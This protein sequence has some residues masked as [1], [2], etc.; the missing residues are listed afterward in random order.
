MKNC[1]IEIAKSKISK[2]S[3]EVLEKHLDAIIGIREIYGLLSYGRLTENENYDTISLIV[4]ETELVPK[5]DIRKN[6]AQS[7]LDEQD[8][9]EKEYLEESK[10]VIDQVL[11]NLSNFP[12]IEEPDDPYAWPFEEYK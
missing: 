8:K 5:G 3:K 1:S 11:K 4:D 6:F 10:D 2:T 7:Y 12:V 9:F